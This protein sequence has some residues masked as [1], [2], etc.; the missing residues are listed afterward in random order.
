MMQGDFPMGLTKIFNGVPQTLHD[1]N[2]QPI[3]KRPHSIII[4]LPLTLSPVVLFRKKKYLFVTQVKYARMLHRKKNCRLFPC[5][6][7]HRVIFSE[8]YILAGDLV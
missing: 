4:V 1:T 3:K 6:T 2:H 5:N 8:N 7:T